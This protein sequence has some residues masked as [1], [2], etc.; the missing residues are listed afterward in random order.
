MHHVFQAEDTQ[1]SMNM[2]RRKAALKN[3]LMHIHQLVEKERKGKDG[4]F[5]IYFIGA[6]A[7][8]FIAC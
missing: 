8:L 5:R 7:W 3:F 1:F 6:G 2:D 4:K